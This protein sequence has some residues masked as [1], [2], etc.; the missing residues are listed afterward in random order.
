MASL[1]TGQPMSTARGEP[2]MGSIKRIHF[3]GI[4]GVGMSGIAEV[5]LNLGYEISGSDLQQNP[6][7]QRL[8]EN[9]A[10]I[11][12][13]HA[14]ENISDSDVVVTSTAV[15]GDNPEVVQAKEQRIPVVPRAEMLA[16]LMRFRF[17]IAVAGTHGKTTTTSLAA[18]LLAEGG[19]D[20]TFVIGGRLNSAGSN[21]RLGEGRYLVAEADESDASFMHLQPMMAVVTNIDADH[22]ETYG[23]DFEKLRQTFI[24]FL[25]HLPFYGLAVL[26][27]DDAEV[28]GILAEVSRPVI[29]Y[30]LTDE[31]DVWAAD[32]QQSEFSTH[33]KV[34]RHDKSEPLDI[35][36]NMPG[37]HNVLNA[38]AGI[39]IAH[40]VGVSD[41]AI[42]TALKHF[43]G[44]SR[45]F[46]SHGEIQT[47][48]GKVLHVDDY[49]HHPSEV[50]ATINAIRGGWPNR[51]LVL[52]F[53]PHRYSRTRDLFE[54]F[55]MVLSE[56]DVLVLLEVYPAGEAPVAGAD[57]RSL[58]RAIRLRGHVEPVFV[59]QVDDL[60]ETLNA[61][62]QDGD[63]LLTLGAGNIGA[64]AAK[65]SELLQAKE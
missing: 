24:E 6:V 17:G 10:K 9:G 36:L 31:A 58:A 1:Q 22:M 52:A 44:I 4:G 26:C 39:A 33:F 57:G 61:V 18:S 30:G 50:A 40:E 12:I 5:L 45:R 62:L 46:Q 23:G 60:P 7:T 28:R 27:I 8:A 51:R 19:L 20:P 11:F 41:E 21:A 59:E 63:L 47:S 48:H 34:Y 35:T 56:V 42:V 49:G 15:H 16:E 64:M 37:Q 32:I 55:S 65:L 2:G 14:A 13:G 54:D 43:Q 53:Q 29:T 38:L 25:H 3:V